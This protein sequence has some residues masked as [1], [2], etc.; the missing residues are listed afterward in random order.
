MILK[1][2]QRFT[3]S[4]SLIRPSPSRVL[5]LLKFLFLTILATFRR[6]LVQ[7]TNFIVQQDEILV[8]RY[9]LKLPLRSFRP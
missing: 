1:V 4:F 6:L 5:I 8:K 7:A 3:S 9:T 2:F